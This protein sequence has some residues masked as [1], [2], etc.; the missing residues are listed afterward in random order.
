MSAAFVVAAD[1]DVA[2]GGVVV[3]DRDIAVVAAA[4][5]D[6]AA[7]V[8]AECA[9]RPGAAA[10]A[11][12]WL[13]MPD[14]RALALASAASFGATDADVLWPVVLAT[15]A[16]AVVKLVLIIVFVLCSDVL[17]L[18]ALYVCAM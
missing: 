4:A 18:G 6:I 10:A 15:I 5:A 2:V 1:D 3:V 14:R 12:W 13:D 17:L 11:T 8:V 7:A 9:A 16:F